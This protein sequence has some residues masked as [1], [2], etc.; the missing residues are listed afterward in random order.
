MAF[1][2]ARG[3]DRVE[4]I[5]NGPPNHRGTCARGAAEWKGRFD[6]LA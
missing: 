5:A 2:Q 3:N 1:Q 6:S 4:A